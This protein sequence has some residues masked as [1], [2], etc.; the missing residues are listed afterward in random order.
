MYRAETPPRA[1]SAHLSQEKK[2]GLDWEEVPQV[3]TGKVQPVV[4]PLALSLP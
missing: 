3:R 4:M 2:L 1:P